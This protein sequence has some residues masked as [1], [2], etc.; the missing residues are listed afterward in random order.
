MSSAVRIPVTKVDQPMLAAV[1]FLVGLGVVVVYSASSVFAGAELGDS[2]FFLKR[3]AVFALIG[4]AA[5]IVGASIDPA[6]LERLA[7]PLLAA[8]F[9]LL[10]AVLVPGIG[11]S[12]GGARR[13]IELGPVALQAGEVMKVGLVL[14]LA[15]SL[16]KKRDRMKSFSVGLLPHVL[17]PGMAMVLLMFEPDFGTSVLLAAVTFIMLFVGGA[18][19]G[20]LAG[21]LLLMIPVALHVVANSPYRMRRV[22]AFLDPWA[23]RSDI[24]YQITESLMTL[25]SGGLFGLGIGDGRQKLFF[26]PAAHTD[27]VFAIIGEEL[28]FLGVVSVIV[29]FFVIGWRGVSAALRH[30]DLFRSYLSLGLVALLSCQALFNIAVV[31]GLVPT[32]GITLPF[33]SYGGSSLII[34]MGMAG[35]L[36]RLVAEANA[37]TRND[38][39]GVVP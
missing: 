14:Y 10:V 11:R 13:W 3:Q 15:M 7:Y 35:L 12:A 19:V 1:L 17:V 25:G 30:E 36:L 33:V 18:R 32:K 27:F 16:A 5:L 9:V 20:Y 28:G 2:L 8:C 34:S 39:A 23:H 4:A 29:A 38:A 21:A 24:G 37:N 31:L 26:L 6:K 22:M